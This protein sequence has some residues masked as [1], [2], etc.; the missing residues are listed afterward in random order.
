MGYIEELGRKAVAAKSRIAA[1]PAGEKNKIL[2]KIAEILRENK[3]AILS[4]NEKDIAKAKENGITEVMVDRLRLTDS[5]IDGIADA[6]LQLVSLEDPVGEVLS[7][8]NRP[9]GMRITKIRVPLGVVG[10][11]YESRPNVTVDAASL[12]LKS[13]NAAILRGG[14]EA[15]HSNRILMKLMQRA[16][17][18]CGFVPETVQLVEDTS[19]D[20]ANEMMRANRYI[21]VLIPRG[22]AGLIQAVVKNATVPVI[23]TGTGNCHI[24]ID[25]TAD[26]DMAVSVTDNGKTQ[27]PSVC[28][29]LETCLVH[30]AVA[31]QFLPKLKD[32][33]DAHQVQIRGCKRTKQILGNSVILA[34]DE[35]YAEE[36]LDYIL[37]VKVVASIEEAIGHIGKYTSGH[38]ECIIT[39]DYGNAEQF[40]K[41]V[42]SACVYVNCSTRFTDGGEFGLGAEIGISTQKLHV[43]GP[44][45][46]RELTTQ[47][48]L[49]NG[50]GQIRE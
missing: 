30:E 2:E 26:L 22:G 38:S 31:E 40:Q 18:L 9:N 42:D 35:D 23:E 27:R 49:I 44:M 14:K 17:E 47:K 8:S 24:Y 28:N 6:C 7:G 11:I 41:E 32:A 10:I 25:G 15:F 3:E 45:G 46:L 5:R 21:D 33:L 34:A 20:V 1:A 37:A 16:L 39:K 43:R 4:E 12:C 19:R 13:G 29:A 36:F 50:N 48:Y